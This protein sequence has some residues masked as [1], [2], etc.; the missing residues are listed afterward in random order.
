MKIYLGLSGSES[1]I[2]AY[3][4]SFS[5]PKNE[6]YEDV[7]C[8]DG[9]ITRYTTNTVKHIFNIN[10]LTIEKADLDVIEAE[11]NRHAVLSLKVEKDTGSDTYDTYS[12]LFDGVFNKGMDMDYNDRREYKDVSFTLKEV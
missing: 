8:E 7:I 6:L 2:T 3:G 4:R 9:S 10:Y 11:Y 1:L 5:Y 12:V